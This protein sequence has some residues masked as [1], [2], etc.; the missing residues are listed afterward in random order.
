MSTTKV[1]EERTP[2]QPVSSGVLGTRRRSM[3]HETQYCNKKGCATSPPQPL[4]LRLEKLSYYSHTHDGK[5]GK[6]RRT[7]SR[8][9]WSHTLVFNTS[10]VFLISSEASTETK[11]ELSLRWQP[12][13]ILVRSLKYTLGFCLL[14]LLWLWGFLVGVGRH[15]ASI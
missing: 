12:S 5:K 13:F 14:T 1:T 11:W 2:R 8:G 10:S 7:P 4:F 15:T 3:H 6:P 9:A